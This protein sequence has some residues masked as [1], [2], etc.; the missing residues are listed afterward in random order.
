MVAVP[1]AIFK[2]G[3]RIA[4]ISWLGVYV[5]E[6]YIAGNIHHRGGMIFSVIS[7]FLLLIV[8]WVLRKNENSASTEP[9]RSHAVVPAPQS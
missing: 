6:D 2:N 1:L 4:A 7:F 8:L 9:R 3:V 5:S